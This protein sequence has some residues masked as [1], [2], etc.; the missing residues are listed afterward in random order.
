MKPAAKPAPVDPPLGD[1]P[2]E[3]PVNDGLSS[4]FGSKNANFAETV[5]GII[6]SVG[7]KLKGDSKQA[8]DP[9]FGD[10]LAGLELPVV[11][12]DGTF[13]GKR[14]KIIGIAAAAVAAATAAGFWFMSGDDAVAPVQQ[15][16]VSQSPPPIADA[17]PEFD[18]ETVYGVDVDAELVR[19]ETALLESRLNDASTALQNVA[20]VEPDHARLPFLNAQLAQLQLR[21]YLADARAAIRD[22]RFEDAGNALNA[23]R[24]LNV[25]E[26]I[27]I[28]A[29]MEELNSAR[30]QQ[31]VDETLALAG[32]RLEEGDLLSPPNDNA[33]Y[34][35]ELVLS[36][37]SLNT[38]AQQGLDALA[39]KLVLRARSEIDAG[40]LGT[41]E[42]L[43]SDARAIDPSSGELT[44]TEAALQA[45]RDE[46]AERERRAAEERRQ[47]E[48]ERQAQ[49]QR[50]A[51]AKRQAE[52]ERKAAASAEAESAA[53][54][55]PSPQAAE[56]SEPLA[57]DATVAAGD[58]RTA[59]SGVE[60]ESLAGESP[61]EAV[62]VNE[63]QTVAISTLTRT[64]Y[65]AP[66]Y[67]R[68]AQRRGESGWVDV[69]FTV[70]LDGSVT[71]V[72]VSGSQPEG[73]FE[74]SAV[75]AVEKWTFE[76]VIE[77]GQAVRR[78]A[79][80]RMMFALE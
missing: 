16:A 38:S 36:S 63:Q 69:V 13:S 78:R 29:V 74:N 5:S 32:A 71:D 2:L 44:A 75:R 1:P 30:S 76:P 41:A 45:A 42:N 77:N 24:L 72:E 37:D 49:A 54:E 25:G 73:M 10:T 51:E 79:G 12:G 52:E 33:R 20:E 50:E 58:G 48:A 68:A 17:D 40:N 60:P 9:G 27:E 15:D 64:K 46:M 57:E 7:E 6:G 11:S 31:R 53:T 55:E 61:R 26:T 59:G 43:L 14:V 4:A 70:G 3:S 67:P 62:A 19:A 66:R 35:Y 21:G 80:V 47:A 56:V 34:Y 22:T 28:D 18:A 8:D 65:V 23:A 39:N